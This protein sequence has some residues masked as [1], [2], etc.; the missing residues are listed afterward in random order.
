MK[1]FRL[2]VLAIAACLSLAI[3]SAKASA[4]EMADST[5]WYA[6]TKITGG[7]DT[8]YNY[9][10]SNRPTT[11]AVP[12]VPTGGFIP[13]TN[14]YRIFD[15]NA[16]TFNIGLVELAV[17]N[18]PVDWFTMRAD[19]DFGHDAELIHATGLGL[20]GEP[21]DLQQAYV[22]LKAPIGSGL[23]FKAGKFVTY[24]GA[25]VIEAWAN[26]NFSRSLLFNYAIPL[27]HTGLM[28]NYAFADW[29]TL[30]IGIVN[31]W[32][33]VID[34]N[35]GKSGHGQVTLKPLE[36]LTWII[37]ATV[38]PELNGTDSVVTAVIDTTLTYTLSPK[39]SFS[40]NYDW[41]HNN[42]FAGT[43]AGGT[44]GSVST[45]HA[46]GSFADWQGVAVYV[47]WKPMDIFGLSLR[48]EIMQD[49][50]GVTF[51][52]VT[53]SVASSRLY[54]GTLT[55]H[56]YLADGL[57]LRFEFRHDQG[58]QTSFLEGNGA[59]RKFQDTVASEIVYAF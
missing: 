44:S 55:S 2:A 36:N 51:T 43:T 22:T 41:G 5:P 32:N 14:A 56:L 6:K 26:N 20:A 28:M 49:N 25:E 29:I 17:E 4:E 38:G 24:N 1:K 35:N 9:N 13:A 34:N 39:W 45:L 53:G 31:G 37:G 21:F 11:V 23:T 19:L 10:V 3:V 8:N 15:A 12:P 27:T 33:N 58:N 16:N 18:S 54:E 48:G 47:N 30:D 50:V 46:S 57:D 7:I 42:P 40:A 52:G 59:S